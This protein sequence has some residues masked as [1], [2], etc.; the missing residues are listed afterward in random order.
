M[1]KFE[2]N[3]SFNIMIL[4][5]GYIYVPNIIDRMERLMR[6]LKIPIGHPSVRHLA[7]RIHIIIGCNVWCQCFQVIRMNNRF[8]T[9]Y[10]YIITVVHNITTNYPFASLVAFQFKQLTL[11]KGLFLTILFLSETEHL[12]VHLV[13][14]R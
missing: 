12:Y 2:F 9:Y 8:Y 4:L 13:R 14:H 11:P 3:L 10:T 1:W 5:I 6:I 7:H